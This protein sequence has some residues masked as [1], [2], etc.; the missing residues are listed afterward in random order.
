VGSQLILKG[1]YEDH[2]FLLCGHVISF[3]IKDVD[4]EMTLKIRAEVKFKVILGYFLKIQLLSE[5]S[6]TK[7]NFY[8]VIKGN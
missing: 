1:A 3:N 8:K 5:M 4:L 2:T 6:F 7:I